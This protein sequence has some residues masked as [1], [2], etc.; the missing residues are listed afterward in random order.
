MN[1]KI[2]EINTINK[3]GRNGPEIR[4]GGINISNTD[5]NDR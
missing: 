1:K 2:R 3:S 5:A 4:A